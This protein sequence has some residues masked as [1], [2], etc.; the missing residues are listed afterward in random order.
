MLPAVSVAFA[1]TLCAPLDS[2][3]VTMLNAPVPAFAV[4]VPI[5]VVPFVS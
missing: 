2:V 5:T 4:P 1:V 3:D